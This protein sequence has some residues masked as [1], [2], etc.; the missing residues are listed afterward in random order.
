MFLPYFQVIWL[1]SVS[2]TMSNAA[3]NSCN[4]GFVDIAIWGWVGVLLLDL[5]HWQPNSAMTCQPP[6]GI[7]QCKLYYKH[8]KHYLP[9]F[10]SHQCVALINYSSLHLF[11]GDSRSEVN[12]GIF[13]SVH[14]RQSSSTPSCQ[15]T[16][17]IHFSGAPSSEN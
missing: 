14:V 6:V 12:T 1:P 4:C 16:W 11:P 3:T 15:W 2:G 9:T 5:I 8:L 7:Q 13:C 10:S 17:L